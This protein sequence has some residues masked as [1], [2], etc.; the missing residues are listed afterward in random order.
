M[1][2]ERKKPMKK[3]LKAFIVCV[4]LA[5]ADGGLTLYNTPDLS[6]E[7]N[8]LVARFHLGWGALITVNLIFLVI[9]FF[10]CRFIFERYQTRVFDVPN[11]RSYISQL[12]YN[13]P[14]KF[15]WSFYRLPKNWTPAWACM[16]YAGYFGT[17]AGRVVVVLEWLAITFHVDMSGYNR[18]RTAY[19]FGRLD[20]VV[21]IVVSVASIF[22]WLRKEY[23]KSAEQ[24]ANASADDLRKG[25]TN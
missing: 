1:K 23:Q 13:R 11:T 19:C 12:F 17:S 24:I 8:P 6:M 16:C 2:N 22:V 5:L 25:M 21:V 9:F 10:A 4:V 3:W 14:D 18:F 7:G 15:I 20:I